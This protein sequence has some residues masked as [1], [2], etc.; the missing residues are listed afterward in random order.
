MPGLIPE[1]S[2]PAPIAFEMKSKAR[3]ALLQEQ[4]P[5]RTVE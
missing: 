4:R 5:G 3:P 1:L 2:R